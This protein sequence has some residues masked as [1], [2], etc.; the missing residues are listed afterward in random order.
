MMKRVLDI[1]LFVLIA[2]VVIGG[3]MWTRA[4]RTEQSSIDG[5]RSAVMLL[6][7]E[8]RLRSGTGSAEL[9]A[10]GWPIRVDPGWF[11]G[12]PPKN[13]LLSN[14]HPWMEIAPPADALLEHPRVRIAIDRSTASFWYNPA[15]GVLRARTPAGVSDR[16]T[17]EVYN[18]VNS[19]SLSSIFGDM[20]APG[21]PVLAVGEREASEEQTALADEID[22]S[23]FEG[24]RLAPQQN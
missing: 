14:D 2:S 16:R 11:K 1:T 20:G 8:I 5:T 7:R 12:S 22:E 6:E 9:N 18:E 4:G 13:L 15:N 21:Q 17:T 24:P 3:V 19:T 10:R 23:L